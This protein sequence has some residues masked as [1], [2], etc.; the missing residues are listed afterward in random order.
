MEVMKMNDETRKDELIMALT[1]MVQELNA[2][3][4]NLRVEAGLKLKEKDAKIA[5]L[6]KGEERTT[7]GHDAHPATVGAVAG[8]SG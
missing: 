1:E 2:R 8:L 3:L 4:I 5:E 6:E 7:N